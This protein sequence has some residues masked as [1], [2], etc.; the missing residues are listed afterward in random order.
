MKI[1]CTI[2]ARGGS[3]GL[4]K[5]NVRLLQGKPLIAHTILQ[6]NSTDIFDAISVSQDLKRRDLSSSKVIDLEHLG[7]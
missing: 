3:K 7:E 4:K 1:I 6:A 2:C 5:K